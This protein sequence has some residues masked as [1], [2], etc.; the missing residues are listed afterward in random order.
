M[1]G[2]STLSTLLGARG[3]ATTDLESARSYGRALCRAG[4]PVLLVKPG[5]KAPAD[6]RST[7]ERTD[8]KGGVHLATSDT[9][10]LDKY[11]KRAYADTAKR[12]CP[13]PLAEGTPTNWGVRLRG[14]GYV[15][16]DADTPEEVESLR[17][18]LEQDGLNRLSPTVVTPGTTDGAHS[19]GGHW[20]FRLPEDLAEAVDA[21]DLPATVKLSGPGCDTSFTLMVGDAYVLTPPSVR[22]AGAYQLVAPDVALPTS[23]E[24]VLRDTLA[25]AAQR[26]ATREERTAEL[27]RRQEDPTAVDSQDEQITSWAAN[28]SWAEILQP[29]GWVATGDVDS[30]GCPIWTAPGSHGSRKSATTHEPVCSAGA[31]S[32]DGNAPVHIWTDN[33]GPE[34]EQAVADHQT[35]TLSKLRVAAYLEHDGNEAAAMDAAGVVMVQGT[36]LDLEAA[37]ISLPE[38]FLGGAG[39]SRWDPQTW[40]SPFWDL[41]PHFQAVRRN[42]WEVGTNPWLLLILWLAEACLRVPRDVVMSVPAPASLNYMALGIGDSGSSKSTALSAARDMWGGSAMLRERRNA[43]DIVQVGKPTPQALVKFLAPTY[44]DVEDEDGGEPTKQVRRPSHP[45]RCRVDEIKRFNNEVERS[46]G[47]IQVVWNSLF[48]GEKVDNRNA[49]AD[50]YEAGEHDYRCVFMAVGQYQQTR[51]LF[52]EDSVDTGFSSRLMVAETNASE[53]ELDARE[54]QLNALETAGDDSPPGSKPLELVGTVNTDGWEN[55]PRDPRLGHLR[56]FP[57]SREV[58]ILIERTRL[59]AR[60]AHDGHGGHL[61]LLQRN[62]ATLLAIVTGATEVTVEHWGW[63][64]HVMDNRARVIAGYEVRM[65]TEARQA[66]TASRREERERDAAAVT[67]QVDAKVQ[68]VLETLRK[69]PGQAE[70]ISRLVRNPDLRQPVL[71]VLDD[72]EGVTV[73]GGDGPR[74]GYTVTWTGPTEN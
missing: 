61:A 47:D 48:S 55:F 24:A 54:E 72:T 3:G 2:N 46:H 34:L 39:L 65:A 33:P 18:F 4:L 66:A 7:K 17:R 29:H 74:G 42:A 40:D 12:G 32:T 69:T 15:V 35:R 70:R 64:Q 73:S 19:G 44:E 26:V 63:A 31:Y 28:T 49:V 16:A 45:V 5:E 36:P 8:N 43:L 67:D 23:L 6:W 50:S 52:N 59:A 51:A 38:P 10:T 9:R 1:Y 11:I 21:A 56:S 58:L 60:R 30:C 37:G 68:T 53:I 14:S 57:T 13:P 71:E 20:W 22:D 62:T 27:E 25:S 41:H